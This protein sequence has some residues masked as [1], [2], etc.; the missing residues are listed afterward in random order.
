M[1]L[2]P[3]NG[4]DF[5]ANFDYDQ[6]VTEVSDLELR[7]LG[8][9]VPTDPPPEEPDPPPMGSAGLGYGSGV[10][11][12]PFIKFTSRKYDSGSLI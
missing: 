11:D 8:F 9:P 3:F 2:S 10:I 4:S 5:F 6:P 12:S 7:R 1:F